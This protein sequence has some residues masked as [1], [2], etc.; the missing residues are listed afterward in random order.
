M[1]A[2]LISSDY[3]PRVNKLKLHFMCFCLGMF[4]VQIGWVIAGNNQPANVM[5][6]KLGIKDKDEWTT[7]NAIITGSSVLGMSIGAFIAGAIVA[8]GR[9]KFLIIFGV[10]GILFT[11]LT[12]IVNLYAIV[13]GRFMHGLAT[14]VFMTGAP[15]ILDET[16]PSH[17]LGTFGTYTNVYANLGI[18]VVMLLGFGLPS[19]DDSDPSNKALLEAD[20]FWR[21]IYGFPII[22]LTIGVTL[23]LTYFK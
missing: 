19:G 18:M 1:T 11:G 6:V 15:R 3:E 12:L 14:G 8:N 5:K 2:A 7:K 4:F 10:V 16:V 9:R 20:E 17:L 22:T 23:L 13:I 21:V